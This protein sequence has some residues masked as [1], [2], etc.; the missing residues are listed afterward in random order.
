M[1]NDSA[2]TLNPKRLALLQ[3]DLSEYTAHT[4]PGW[5]PAPHLDYICRQLEAVEAGEITRLI[6]S[7]PHRHGKSELSTKSYP[8]WYLGLHPDDDVMILS[9]GAELSQEFS[10][11]NREK[12]REF[13]P[14]IFGISISDESSAIDR[15][16]LADHRGSV[17]AVGA[18]GA[19]N[20]RGADLMIIDDIF[21]G[22]EDV[23]SPT[24]RSK[25][26]EWYRRVA[27]TRLA[28]GGRIVIVNT[29]MHEDDLIGYLLQEQDRGGEEW[30]YIRMPAIA[31]ENDVLGRHL[32]EALWP[33]RYPLPELEA[34]RRTLS[35]YE[36]QTLYQQEPTSLEGSLF[37]REHFRYFS[38]DNA[39]YTIHDPSGNRVVPV[40]VCWHVQTCDTAVSAKNDAD[41]FVVQTWAITPQMEMLLVDQFRDH[42]EAPDQPS[43]II[44]QYLKWRPVLV[45]IERA[46]SG[47]GLIQL[48]QRGIATGSGIIR[49][50]IYELHPDASKQLRAL[51]ASAYYAQHMIYHD[52]NAPWLPLYEDELAAFPY[53]R[54]DDQIDCVAYA[55]NIVSRWGEM[56]PAPSMDVTEFRP[57]MDMVDLTMDVGW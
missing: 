40:S 8:S 42:V 33:E 23:N 22:P 49:V 54:H 41:W 19:I 50:P 5:R 9:Y 2:K 15:W 45:G 17:V 29:R 4:A 48:L 56:I 12:I 21:K 39:R 36:W 30:T 24:Q 47:I 3:T 31:C 44:S 34:L 14:T 16:G 43:V 26:I 1:S 18:G 11:H 35:G 10:R 20:G 6:I 13:G 7:V 37:R 28:P 38:Q 55:A 25:R 52:I 51:P 27:R 53:G 57:E 46:S 32:G